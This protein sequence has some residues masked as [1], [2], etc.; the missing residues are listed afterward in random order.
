METI[1]NNKRA[2]KICHL[3]YMYS[4]KATRKSKIQYECSQGKTE[5]YMYI[6]IKFALET[7]QPLFT[8]S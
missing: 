4:R 7:V 5:C 2:V 1:K 3:G 8:F 6:K